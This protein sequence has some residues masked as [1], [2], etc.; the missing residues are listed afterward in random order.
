MGG[1]L[2]TARV[3]KSARKI[4]A[5]GHTSISVPLLLIASLRFGSRTI[6]SLLSHRHPFTSLAFSR[7]WPAGY[8]YSFVLGLRACACLCREALCKRPTRE[9]SRIQPAKLARPTRRPVE[10]IYSLY[11]S[12]KQGFPLPPGTT[13]LP[14]YDGPLRHSTAPLCRRPES[15][16]E[17]FPLAFGATGLRRHATY[18]LD[19]R[20]NHIVTLSL[21]KSTRRWEAVTASRS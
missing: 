12:R 17:R 8:S 18:W 13:H 7:G 20:S 6:P 9:P 21:P 1:P 14:P 5:W 10:Y 11:S 4:L 19:L 16:I 3:Q 15:S 2:G